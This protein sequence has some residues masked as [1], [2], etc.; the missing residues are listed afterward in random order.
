MK[1]RDMQSI[2]EDYEFEKKKEFKF[3]S[4]KFFGNKL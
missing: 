4:K 2:F 3:F 1:I